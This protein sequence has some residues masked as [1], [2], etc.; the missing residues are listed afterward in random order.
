MKKQC[1]D[2]CNEDCCKVRWTEL[3]SYIPALLI[4]VVACFSG[5]LELALIAIAI[6]A[7]VYEMKGVKKKVENSSPWWY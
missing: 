6:F 7:L 2:R 4:L 3:L 5:S 1:E